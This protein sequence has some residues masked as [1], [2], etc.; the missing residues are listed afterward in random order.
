VALEIAL[1]AVKSTRA[2]PAQR[3]W[4][5]HA[6]TEFFVDPLNRVRGSQRLP[7]RFGE[8]EEREEY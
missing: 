6:A 7:L 3:P 1:A 4:R 5:L 8:C 2:S